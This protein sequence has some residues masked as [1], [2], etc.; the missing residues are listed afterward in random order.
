MSVY[1][2]A[3]RLPR[4]VV[5]ILDG[6]AAE[7]DFPV[8][9]EDVFIPG[10]EIEIQ[11]GYNAT[12]ETIFKGLIVKHS[13][14]IRG[15]RSPELSIE[16]LD[17]AAKLTL[18][19]KNK[20]YA[21]MKD[22]EVIEELASAASLETDVEATTVKHK[23]LVQYYCTDWD[24]MI[25]RAESNGKLCFVEDGKFV[26]KK[27]DL[28]QAAV[29]NLLFGATILELDAEMDA[30]YQVTGV[31]TVGWD[32]AEQRLITTTGSEPGLAEQGNIS[33]SD[34]ADVFK[35]D[36]Y[37][38]QHA[39]SMPEDELQAWADAQLLKNRLAKIRGRARLM[40]NALVKP[41]VVV[42]LGGVGERFNGKVYVT[43]V[44]H[45][46][47]DGR[48]NMDIQFGLAPQ[49]FAT[50]PDVTHASASAVI[51]GIKGLHTGIVTDLEDP[52]GGFRVK[53]KLPEIS[54]D[55]EGTWARMASF[56]AGNNRTAF[57]RPEIDDEVIVGFLH[58]DPNFPVILGSLH[59]AR[60]TSP[61]EHSNDNFKKIIFT[62]SELKMTFD[63]EKKSFTVETP[64]GKKI[65]IDDDAK[66]IKVEDENGNKM[67]MESSAIK[68]ESAGDL[69]L[70]A[71]GEIKLTAP[72][73]TI[74]AD[75]AVEVD[76]G[77]SAKVGS[78]GTCT[79][80]GSLVQI[81]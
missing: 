63:D 64:G 4:A 40:G 6:S 37:H 66:I 28:S 17:K 8:S 48:W 61:E 41:G 18:T 67:T 23:E 50:Q 79:I 39:G 33:S 34:L 54:A 5:N 60:N 72:N 55:E 49:W 7:S 27:P 58:E 59:S 31:E 73:I 2:E 69:E 9:N 1:K 56:Y 11:A 32:P 75:A 47:Q 12:N 53:V 71:A 62:A 29:L 45:E 42:E 65:S 24:F 78:S 68:I 35:T 21:E 57:F 76:G 30:R 52:D 16:C 43:G 22:S 44:R 74:K 20:Y 19:R 10:N 46:L 81:N 13:L 51:P 26:V 15:D 77:G 14:K 38:L 70:K 80:K 3:N 25:T 36:P